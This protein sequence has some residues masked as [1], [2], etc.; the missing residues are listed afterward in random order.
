M[1]PLSCHKQVAQSLSK[2]KSLLIKRNIFA[3]V[4]PSH[5]ALL[6]LPIC[7]CLVHDSKKVAEHN[8]CRTN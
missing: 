7:N 4:P 5:N 2:L 6:T 1:P 3:Y 8:V